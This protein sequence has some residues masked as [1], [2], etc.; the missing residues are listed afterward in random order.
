MKYNKDVFIHN[1]EYLVEH[2]LTPELT[3]IDKLGKKYHVRAHKT[4]CDLWNDYEKIRVQDAT[5]LTKHVRIRD[6]VKIESDIDFRFGVEFQTT[7]FNDEL[8]FAPLQNTDQLEIA[9]KSIAKA[10]GWT[11]FIY[12]LTILFIFALA[13]VSE[14]LPHLEWLPILIVF[15][16]AG[17]TGT[18]FILIFT[19]NQWAKKLHTINEVDKETAKALLKQ[20]KIVRKSKYKFATVSYNSKEGVESVFSNSLYQI[21]RGTPIAYFA[22]LNIVKATKE[23]ATSPSIFC[24]QEVNDFILQVEELAR[25]NMVPL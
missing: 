10:T 8:T 13:F 25:N 23:I 21:S 18:I 3:L 20:V 12:V 9:Q 2:D 24:N 1:L 11:V 6:I 4:H 17:M 7:L 14:F 16:V 19:Q 15:P 22:Y 5:E